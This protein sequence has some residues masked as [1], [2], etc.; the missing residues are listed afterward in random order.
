MLE[1]Q[2]V[3]QGEEPMRKT[4]DRMKNDFAAIR[5]GRA[6]I[7]LVEGVKV[8]SYG[9]VMPINQLAAMS[10]PDARTIEIRPWDASQMASIEK[11]I[12]KSDLG[13]TPVNDGKLIRLSIPTLTEDRRKEL[14]KVLNKMAEEF[15][16]AIRNERRHIVDNI[17]KAEKDKQISEDERKKGETDSQKLTD[18]YIKKIDDLLALKEKELMEV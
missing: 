4:I 14:I 16:I 7:A 11:A 2:L 6:S 13:L 9:A 12:M 18:T 3:A 10:V 15:K 17:K 8:E 5:T 1:K